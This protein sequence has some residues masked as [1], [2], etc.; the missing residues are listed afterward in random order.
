MNGTG[1]ISGASA[2]AKPPSAQAAERSGEG[3]AFARLLGAGAA[4]ASGQAPGAKASARPQTGTAD[5]G[6]GARQ[7]AAASNAPDERAEVGTQPQPA[8]QTQADG[9]R[10]VAERASSPPDAEETEES[11]AAADMHGEGALPAAS[12]GKAQSDADAD[13][14]ADQELAIDAVTALMTPGETRRAAAAAP[15][16]NEPARPA[17]AR[18]PAADAPVAVL[19]AA[20]EAE[21]AV[22]T[23][24]QKVPA[25][26]P[27]PV[28]AR[29]ERLVPAALQQL[30]GRAQGASGTGRATGAAAS[31][32]PGV[33]MAV[34]AASAPG[35]VGAPAAP[36]MPVGTASPQQLA[37]TAARLM[38]QS[39]AEGKWQASL[40]LD[41]PE[42]GRVEVQIGRDQNALSAHFVT[43]TSGARIA[44]EE[45]M[46]QLAQ[47]LAE[48]GM[49][50]GEASVSQQQGRDGSPRSAGAMAAGGDAGGGDG[51]MAPPLIPESGAAL[52][53]RGFFEGWA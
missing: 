34:L 1:A 15:G 39:V 3:G 35:A 5:S 19:R 48:Q 31:E 11:L 9:G 13:T 23:V 38:V 32:S 30:A 20:A 36:A 10:A 28:P 8:P 49:S 17:S 7:S 29:S 43:A 18:P 16:R 37:E 22:R 45:A 46:P 12:E 52:R 21:R 50:L 26:E 14:D 25:V 24:L 51:E 6:D 33:A 47:Q 42:L 41:P 27:V 4:A 40:R 2:S 44:M 53:A